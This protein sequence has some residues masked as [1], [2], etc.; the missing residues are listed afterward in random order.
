MCSESVK[1]F[2]EGLV[3]LKLCFALVLLRGG[4]HPG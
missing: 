3:E 4:F 1:L 2:L